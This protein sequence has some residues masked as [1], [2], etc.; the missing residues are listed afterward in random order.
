MNKIRLGLVKCTLQEFVFEMNR[1]KLVR[2]AL[3]AAR[4]R[5]FEALDFSCELSLDLST[6]NSSEIASVLRLLL[7]EFRAELPFRVLDEAE[8]LVYPMRP[9]Q[10]RSGSADAGGSAAPPR[11]TRGAAQ[12]ASVG[13]RGGHRRDDGQGGR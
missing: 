7:C 5:N 3:G 4:N 8:K 6:A 9:V 10:Q 1:S 2:N 11:R 13:G 12:P